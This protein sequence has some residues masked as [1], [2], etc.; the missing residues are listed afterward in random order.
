[1]LRFRFL[2]YANFG[3]FENWY[4][5]MAKKGYEIET[6]KF[7]FMHF[8]KKTEPKDVDYKFVISNNEDKYN[9]FSK[10]E[11][12]DL[13][14]MA[15]GYG[16]DFIF[17]S[18]NM[19]L[20]KTK[21]KDKSLYNDDVEE[22]KILRTSVKREIISNAILSVVLLL[23]HFFTFANFLSEE[24]YYSNYSMVLGPSVLLMLIF[25]LLALVDYSVF[26]RRN[27][28]VSCS[29]DLKFSR[30]SFS[31]FFVYLIMASLI[32]IIVGITLQFVDVNPTLG[33]KY[34][35]LLWSPFVLMCLLVFLFRKKI[36]TMNISTAS[37]KKFF[38]LMVVAIFGI[39]YFMSYN[40]INKLPYNKNT[41]V[42]GGYEVT[43]LS[44]GIFLTEHK[45]YSNNDF[46][47]ERTISKDEDTAKNL[48]KRIIK[49][50]KNHPYFGEH[51]KDI[52][53]EYEYDKT[54]KLSEGNRYAVLKGRVILVV[55]GEINNPEI[56][57]EIY[58]FLGDV[59]GKR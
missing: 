24:F 18:Y 16:Y 13:N 17:K 46:S 40:I 25:D 34:T 31:K 3:L 42:S 4:K 21:A 33:L 1:M 27:R 6:A 23:L 59:N 53:K 29:R 48:Y 32:L 12:D 51:V 11:L 58:K 28:E 54:Y 7:S 56:K 50:A 30:L 14:E 57:T 10:Q 9:A 47:V 5:E 15:K 2:T 19:N 20:Y 8:F 38:I 55:E 44:K 41:E 43:E 52:S 35:L 22:L 45:I 39:N 36:K 49:N 37:K 26:Y